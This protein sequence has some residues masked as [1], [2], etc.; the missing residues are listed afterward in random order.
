VINSYDHAV[1][2]NDQVVAGLIDGF[3][4]LQ[5]NGLQ[6]YFSDHDEDVFDSPGHKILG[7]NEGRPSE[8]MKSRR[9]VGYLARSPRWP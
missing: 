7:R 8:P 9:G 1:L 4:A 6:V 5:A 3:S 2:Y